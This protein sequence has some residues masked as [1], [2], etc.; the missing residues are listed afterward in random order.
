MFLREPSEQFPYL[1][2]DAL[3]SMNEKPVWLTQDMNDE[4][5]GGPDWTLSTCC[6]KYEKLLISL[7]PVYLAIIAILWNTVL[8]KPMKLVAVFVHEMSHAIACWLTCGTVKEINVNA[9]EGGV[10]KYNGGCR[11]LI[12]PAGYLGGAFWGGFFVAMS[13]NRTA[14]LVTSIMFCVAMLASLRFNPNKTMIAV[15][16]FFVALTIAI[17]VVDKM[18]TPVLNYLTLFYGVFIGA[19]SIYDIYDDCITRTVKGSDSHACFKLI[20]CCLPKLVGLQFA[21]VALAF[22]AAGV[23][24]ALVWIT[25]SADYDS[26]P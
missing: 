21:L 8:V 5:T 16:F 19:F 23:Y 20:P 15:N 6:G 17:I 3:D 24:L 22:Q 14:A 9:D 13:G 25:T 18:Y 2:S 1:V 10:T 11:L 4:T 12:I 26:T 7:V